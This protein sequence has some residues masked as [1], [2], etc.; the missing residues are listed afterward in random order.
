MNVTVY[1]SELR[2]RISAPPSKSA[3]HRA[4]IAAALAHG[5]S[6]IRGV[7]LSSD[8][9][10]TVKACEALGCRVRIEP[11]GRYNTLYIE[12]GLK[13][14]VRARI[15][16]AESGSTLRF[17]IPVA[18]TLTG[19]KTFSGS[20][21]LPY[22]PIDE[23]L[24]IFEKQGLAY[25][26]P[27]DK[28]LPLTVSGSLSGGEYELG[29]NVSSQYITG[30]LFAL[31]LLDAG[32]K[33]TVI[34][35]LESKGYVDMT[36]DTLSKSGVNIKQRGHSFIIEGNQRYSPQSVTVEGDYS[37]AAFFIV[38]AALSGDI[39][40]EGL[41]P[42]SLQPDRAIVDIMR[43]MG[44]DIEQTE[45]SLRVKCSKLYGID[46]DVSQCPDLVPPIAVAAALAEGTTRITGAARLRIKESDRLRS[47]S[48]NLRTIGIETEE[49]DDALIIRGGGACEGTVDS[50]GDHR[51]PMA[52]SALA[53]GSKALSI[54]GAE[55]VSKSYPSF[56]EDLKSLGGSVI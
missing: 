32:S 41:S 3:A 1:P 34:G 40:I 12:G 55:C 21:R 26:K 14:N 25:N 52:F 46:V 30:L 56:F 8:L 33:I 47:M 51:I 38:G 49:L 15:D 27:E 42:S 50:F 29:G 17:I 31:P 16:C 53:L 28:N 23:Y 13:E 9:T 35:T 19:E 20:G 11:Y 6:V 45:N 18:C 54:Q 2:G 44:A 7:D 43:R 22:R 4:V 10:A 48:A 24:M 39:T 37:Q 36:L 5:S